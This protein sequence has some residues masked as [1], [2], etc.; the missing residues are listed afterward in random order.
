MMLNRRGFM[1]GLGASLA[2]PA[3]VRAASIMPVSAR[4]LD[5]IPVI[6]EPETALG[7]HLRDRLYTHWDDHFAYRGAKIGSTLRV[8][9]PRDFI[10]A[11]S[12]SP[13][14][15]RPVTMTLQDYYD[16]ILRPAAQRLEQELERAILDAGP[17]KWTRYTVEGGEMKAMPVWPF[18]DDPS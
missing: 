11:P 7:L 12:P 13:M 18:L 16:R 17:N 14:V 8:R 4:A 2:A 9:L 3:V 6:G 10:L 1:L 15:G 5:L